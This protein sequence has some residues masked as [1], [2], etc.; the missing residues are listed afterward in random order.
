MGTQA[1]QADRTQRPAARLEGHQLHHRP[2]Q[3]ARP[4]PVR[5]HPGLR[6]PA[7][8]HLGAEAGG[9]AGSSAEPGPVR[10][11]W[12]R[13][14]R[15]LRPPAEGHPCASDER[16]HLRLPAGV[17]GQAGARF[18]RC[19]RLGRLPGPLRRRL[20]RRQGYLRHRCADPRA[21]RQDPGERGTE[22]RPVGGQLR[23]IRPGH[24]HRGGR[25]LPHLVRGVGLPD[26]PLDA[27]GLATAAL[28]PAPPRGAVPARAVE[29]D[30][31]FAAVPGRA[32]LG[33]GS[34][35]RDG[36]AALLGRARIPGGR[37]AEPV[38]AGPAPAGPGPAPGR[39]RRHPAQPVP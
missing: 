12:P 35:A 6:H 33:A 26:A 27:R 38:P 30:G 11:R 9:Q 1:W 7:A 16:G 37:R 2:G 21:G 14:P 39:P 25:R 31:Q 34:A 4:F 3:D 18:V 20:L 15:V 23:A 13:R 28:D 8:A 29:D 32:V 5:H 19:R 17:L 22:P 24:R 36:S 10:R